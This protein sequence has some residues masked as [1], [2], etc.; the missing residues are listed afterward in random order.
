MRKFIAGLTVG[1][2]SAAAIFLPLWLSARRDNP[3]RQTGRSEA[4]ETVLREFGSYD[5]SSPYKLLFSVKTT[6][7]IIIETNGVKTVR[8]IP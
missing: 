6:D 1:F 7:V 2:V 5:G 4:A 8:V 3:G